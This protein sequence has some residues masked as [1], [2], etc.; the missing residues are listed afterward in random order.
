MLGVCV[1][2]NASVVQQTVSQ[3]SAVLPSSRPYNR[4]AI[5]RFCVLVIARE[6]GSFHDIYVY[7]WVAGYSYLAF[8]T[9]I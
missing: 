8:A 3:H 2:A 1:E 4:A 6:K 7:N 9:D 5:L